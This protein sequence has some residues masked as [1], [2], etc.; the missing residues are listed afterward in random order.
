MGK[1]GKWI[2]GGLGWAL[3]GPIGALIGFMFGSLFDGMQSGAYEYRL[4]HG[5][6]AY[7]QAEGQTYTQPGDFVVSLLVLAAAVMKADGKVLKSE[8]DYV[9]TFL[10]QQFGEEQTRQNILLLR[11]MLKKEYDLQEVSQQVGRYMDYASKLQLLHFLFGIS[12]A[13][14]KVHPKE[15]EVIEKISVFLRISPSDFKSVKAMFVKDNYN[16]YRI[17]EITPDASDDEVKKAYR[18]MA[19]KY[20][21]D[22]VSHLGIEIQEAAKVKFQELQAAY[23]SIKKERGIK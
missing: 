10:R 23:I 14:G 20:H 6:G 15:V 22:R 13:D 19:L 7:A 9:R 4:P 5:E 12:S 11:E 8:L 3:G 21:P 17:L 2:G 18:E 16:N 1:Y